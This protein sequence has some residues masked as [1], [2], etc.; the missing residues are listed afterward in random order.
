MQMHDTHLLWRRTSN[1][2]LRGLHIPS[3]SAQTLWTCS[4]GTLFILL[5][6]IY[7]WPLLFNV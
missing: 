2:Q 3:G 5:C 1:Q 6:G 4:V 7:L